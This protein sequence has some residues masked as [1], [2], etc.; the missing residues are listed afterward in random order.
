MKQDTQNKKS[1]RATQSTVET[2]VVPTGTKRKK[3]RFT[4]EYKLSI[5]ERLEACDSPEHKG[6]ILRQEGL[7]SS[8]IANWR[9]AQRE[10]TLQAL[11]PKKRGPKPEPD[12][13]LK[14]QLK[15]L[16]R[17]NE[18]LQTELYKAKTIIDVQKKLSTF[19]GVELPAPEEEN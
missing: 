4:A 3:R 7:Y 8:H 5:L 16:Q 12:A 19:L 1:A 9:K 6:A 18:K 15:K 17:E 11:S 13:E 14:A 2:E 10:G